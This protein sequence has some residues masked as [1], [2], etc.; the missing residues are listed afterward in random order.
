MA[1]YSITE[2]QQLVIQNRPIY[3]KNNMV[4]YDTVAFK[5]T[6]I[7]RNNKI[8]TAQG[9][10]G[11][12]IGF[13]TESGILYF[14]IDDVNIYNNGIAIYVK[15]DSSDLTINEADSPPPKVTF[16]DSIVDI[17]STG[18]N[19]VGNGIKKVAITGISIFAIAWLVKS[20]VLSTPKKTIETAKL[21][22]QQNN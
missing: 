5:P 7:L 20:L 14:R 11:P 12:I 19:S 16:F 17:I 2:V 6:P 9:Y 1:Q 3:A 4:I 22:K 8:L 18:S 15:A 21:L 13:A 10:L